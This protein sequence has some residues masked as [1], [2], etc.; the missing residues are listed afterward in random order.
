MIALTD[1]FV[2]MG[3]GLCLVGFLMELSDKIRLFNKSVL[4]FWGLKFQHFQHQFT[5][6]CAFCMA[7]MHFIDAAW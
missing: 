2:D 1:S 7:P 4:Q 5:G 6:V 3:T